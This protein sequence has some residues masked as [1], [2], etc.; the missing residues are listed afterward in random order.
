MLDMLIQLLKMVFYL[1]VNLFKMLVQLFF[2][3]LD[4]IFSFLI[5]RFLALTGSLFS[6]LIRILGVFLFLILLVGYGREGV[7]GGGL[8]L[9]LDFGDIFLMNGGIGVFLLGER[10]Y[11]LLWLL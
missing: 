7:A 10:G 8:I 9:C 6:S 11:C 5:F 2:D 3:D 4:K 1:L